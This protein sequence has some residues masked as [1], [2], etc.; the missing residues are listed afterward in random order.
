MAVQFG[1][2]K[3][4]G[5]SSPAGGGGEAS[6][7]GE[8]F[9]GTELAERVDTVAAN[10]ALQQRFEREAANADFANEEAKSKEDGLIFLGT[11]GNYR[12]KGR[13]FDAEPRTL[14]NLHRLAVAAARC[15]EIQIVGDVVNIVRGLNIGFDDPSYPI[16][17]GIFDAA[18]GK[19]DPNSPDAIAL[20]NQL[21]L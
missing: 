2:F 11:R 16:W 6:S 21:K 5:P 3:P 15:G 8:R 13:P 19:L 18:V 20:R 12:V 14:G 9:S 7:G 1:G 4:G 10:A 17:R